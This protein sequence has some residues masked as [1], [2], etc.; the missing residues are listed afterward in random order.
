MTSDRRYLNLSEAAA[1]L[2]QSRKFLYRHWPD[3]LR[4]GVK[5]MRVPSNIGPKGRLYFESAS[6]DAY[7]ETCRIKPDS[8]LIDRLLGS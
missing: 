5:I 2:G 7:M 4:A 3:L 1:Y 8:G 6:L